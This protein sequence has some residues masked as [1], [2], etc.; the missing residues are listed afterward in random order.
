MRQNF[1]PSQKEDAFLF[2]ARDLRLHV[3]GIEI[4]EGYRHMIGRIYY[5]VNCMVCNTDKRFF[6]VDHL[7]PDRLLR[8]TG[9]ESAIAIN[10]VVLC[11][12][13]RKGDKGCNLTKGARPFVP[14]GSGLAYTRSSED[15]N[16]IPI[17]ERPFPYAKNW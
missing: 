17:G 16:Y 3:S 8:G 9:R 13:V 6:N 4:A 12:S 15:M 11:S 5:C 10:A 1:T 14:V 7:A 2:N